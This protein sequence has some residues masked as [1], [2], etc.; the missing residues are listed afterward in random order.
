MRPPGGRRLWSRRSLTDWLA[1]ELAG[2]ERLLVGIDHCFSLPLRYFE[3]HGLLRDWRVFLEDF[4]EHWP[5]N[6]SGVRVDDVRRGRCGRGADRSGQATW[7]RQTDI[8]ARA[9]SPFHF[10]VPGSVAKS[11]HAGLPCL[12][13]LAQLESSPHVW[14]FDGW[15]PAEGRSVIAEVYPRLVSKRFPRRDRTADQHDA[16]SIARALRQADETA[17]LAEAFSPALPSELRSLAELEGWIL[18]PR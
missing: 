7:R 10:D 14:P 17:L 18:Q 15:L 4:A 8:R 5:T 3:S 11:T 9:K 13:E 2:T 1:N 6:R 16:Y 12:L